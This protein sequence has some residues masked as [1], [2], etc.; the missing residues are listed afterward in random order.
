M[1]WGTETSPTTAILDQILNEGIR[2]DYGSH[3]PLSALGSKQVIELLDRA[4]Q[5]KPQFPQTFLDHIAAEAEGN[6]YMLI[7]YLQ[8]AQDGEIN[9]HAIAGDLPVPSGIRGLLQT[10]LALLTS[11]ASQILQAAAVIGRTF[12]IELLQ[13]T[14]G[15]SEDEIIQG[16]EELIARDLIR[17]V[18]D[19]SAFQLYNIRY[20]FKHEQVRSIVLED[21][22][23]IRRRLL[24]RRT[25]EALEERQS[26]DRPSSYNGQIAFHYQHAGSPEIA[27]RYYYQAGQENRTIHANADALTHF[28]SALALGYPQKPAIL[29]EMG[30]LYTLK[31][32]Y[33]LAIQQ[34]EA[35]ASFEEPALLPTIEQ[36]IGQVYL[37]RGQWELATCHFEAALFDLGA[38]P[39]NQ[40]RAFEARVHADLSL[41]LYHRGLI[42]EASSLADE[43]LTLAE[44]GDDP[45]ALAQAHNLLGILARAQQDYKQALGHL[46]QSLSYTCQLDDPQGKIAALNNLA[47]AQADLDDRRAALETVVQ[48]IDESL[49]LGD[50][51]LEA[52]LR[53]NYADILRADGNT[54]EAIQQLKMAA[55]IFAEIG[56]RV[57]DW[58]PEIWK[59]VEW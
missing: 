46:E 20:D 58:E 11:S 4:T 59:L 22:S 3:L 27:A 34:Y 36:K 16:I 49:Q 32:D 55:I 5:A 7:E 26:H 38:I 28:Q 43:T 21:A 15:R 17:E 14:S 23:L 57:E 31:G 52:A 6:P 56:Q 13:S 50:R 47:L 29:V 48:A 8:A 12:D 42:D 18:A 33:P 24:H 37:R 54:E 10:R 40:R 45:L 41:A 39:A 51:H 30:D 9:T 44:S 1:S 53:S 35:A 19:Q 2:Q 25:A